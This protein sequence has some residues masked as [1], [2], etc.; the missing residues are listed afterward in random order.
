VLAP[1]SSAPLDPRSI[2]QARSAVASAE[3]RLAEANA[4]VVQA[5]EAAEQTRRTT[6]RIQEVAELGGISVDARERAELELAAAVR[7]TEAARARAQ[8]AVSEVAA[9]RAALLQVDPEAGAG[10]GD[11]PLRAPTSGR[12]LRVLERSE[13]IVPA[14]T[15]LIEIGDASRLEVV[16]DVL[17]TEAVRI[18]PGAP[19][20]LDQ[21]GGDTL[22]EGTVL[23]VEPSAFTRV[24]ALG[25]EEQRVNV[26]AGL[27]GVPPGL[28]DAY[29]VDARIVL[30]A[31]ADVLKVSNSALFRS[32]D[33]WAVFVVENGRARQ[34][35][36][37]I[38]RRG[39]AEAQVLSG[40]TA[41][42]E[43]VLFPSDRLE[44]GARVRPDR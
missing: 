13:R 2:A 17:S 40:L 12:I 16:V 3:A 38:G 15:P 33:Q 21:W 18:Q 37:E 14:G 28:G 41:G 10:N 24:S 34:R 32:G 19:I 5:E 44:D 25:V 27:A 4:R 26:V 23:R 7:E 11:I 43:V 29:R 20:R 39:V 22:L 9:A 1:L 6:A 35:A 36:V 8:G 30:W 31:E 42:D